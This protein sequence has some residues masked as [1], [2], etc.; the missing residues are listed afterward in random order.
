M[1]WSPFQLSNEKNFPNFFGSTQVF[2]TLALP[3]GWKNFFLKTI[4]FLNVIT[5]RS[6]WY[7]NHFRWI[8]QRPTKPKRKIKKKF[9]V[10][11]RKKSRKLK[12]FQNRDPNHSTQHKK[13]L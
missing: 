13:L 4:L 5:R 9:Y 6:F 2:S 10:T 8:P 1:D 7:I 12:M 11:K 3:G